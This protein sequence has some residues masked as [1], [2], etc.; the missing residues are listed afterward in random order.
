[1]LRHIK[2]GLSAFILLIL[3][4]SCQAPERAADPVPDPST[5]TPSVEQVFPTEEPTLKPNPTPTQLS[6]E[7][8]EQICHENAGEVQDYQ[9][10]WQEEELFGRVYTPPCYPEIGRRYPTLYLLHG[11]TETEDQ[12]EDLGLYELTDDLITRGEI[13]P[14]III[15]PREDTWVSLRENPFADQLVQVL[16][17]WV[18]EEFQTL[19]E[20]DYR[21]VGGVS[22]GGNWAIRLGMMH[23]GTFTALGGHS[24]PLFYGDLNRLPGWLEDIPGDSL[25]RIYLD[26]AEGDTNL[27]ESESLRDIL[28]QA[29][30]SLEWK[31]YPGLHNGDYWSSHLAEYLLWY[32]AGWQVP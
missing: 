17:P 14:L 19:A 13:P 31:L 16:I 11:A 26:I 21:A 7:S 28:E 1:M 25:P 27:P 20:R 8:T 3:T 23:W 22:R 24:A 29:G 9:I 2:L 5:I 4:T 30:V 10:S 12:W 18:D 32:S 15:M 6:P